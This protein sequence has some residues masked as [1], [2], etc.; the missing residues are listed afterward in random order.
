[1]KY[2]N[3]AGPENTADEQVAEAPDISETLDHDPI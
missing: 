1:M 2:Q 3:Q